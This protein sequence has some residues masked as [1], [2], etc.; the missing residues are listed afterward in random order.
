MNRERA[1]VN[2]FLPTFTHHMLRIFCLCRSSVGI[3]GHARRSH[4][5]LY[6]SVSGVGKDDS[7]H[8]PP[9]SGIVLVGQAGRET[10]Q[11]CGQSVEQARQS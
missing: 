5:H 3:A 1:E 4:A 7:V 6:D 2:K 9:E 10:N 8:W 11:A